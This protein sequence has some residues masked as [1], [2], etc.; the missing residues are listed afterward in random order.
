MRHISA[1][2]EP[3]VLSSLLIDLC[4]L[5]LR[6]GRTPR[7]ELMQRGLPLEAQAGP[8]AYPHPVPLIWFQCIDD[9]EAT[10]HAIAEK[11]TGRATT[12]T[13]LTR[14]SGSATWRWSSSTPAGVTSPRS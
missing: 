10:R 6:L 3:E 2:K 9:V 5:D 12:A 7:T 4:L 1:D 11:P 13:S 8:A 14:L